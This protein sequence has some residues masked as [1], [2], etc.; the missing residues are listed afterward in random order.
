MLAESLLE[1]ESS[2][3]AAGHVVADDDIE[4]TD[5]KGMVISLLALVLSVPALI[6]A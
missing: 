1:G 2:L 4:M 3:K 5:K 6:G